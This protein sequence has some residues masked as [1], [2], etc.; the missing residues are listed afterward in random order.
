MIKDYKGMKES[1]F[2]KKILFY[3]MTMYSGGAE[4]VVS[5]LSNYFIKENDVAIATLINS[6]I[7]YDLNNR[8]D[9]LFSS[10]NC[11]TNM[12]FR[13]KNSINLLKNT[14]KYNPD[15]IIAFCPTMCFLACFFKIFFKSFKDIKL[16][17]SERND[18]YSEYKNFLFKYI[19]N[20]LYSKSDIIVFQTN[21]AKSFF[22]EKVQKKG[23]IITNPINEK[24]LNILKSDK[25]ENCIVNVGRLEPQKNQKLLINACT[26]VFKKY[27]NWKLKIYGEGNLKKELETLI[28]DLK[29]E[30]NI[31]LMGRCNELNKELPKNKIFV[32]SSNF[33]G[34][35][36]ALMEAMAC[37][38]ACISTDCPCG[39]PNDLIVN[40]KN[41]ILIPVNDIK[42]MEKE[43]INLIENKELFNRLCNVHNNFNTISNI[44]KKWEELI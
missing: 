36:N 31:F 32:L 27:P 25:K 21:G 11:N 43:I 8:I 14:K 7:D 42:S 17:I 30:K 41:G 22:N 9:I 44:Y 37:G 33:E 23:V 24:F 34:M 10:K 6:R 26:N 35:P 40:Y 1:G 3:S 2:L 5:N 38:L 18:P 19:A 16:I 13:I 20:L 15:V 29:M 28:I 39:G 12:F 4:R